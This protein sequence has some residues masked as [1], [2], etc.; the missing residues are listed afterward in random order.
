MLWLI[1]KTLFAVAL[2]IL[3]AIGVGAFVYRLLPDN[4]RP[5]ERATFILLGGI[6]LLSTALFLVGQIWFT[7][8]SITLVLAVAAAHMIPKRLS[9]PHFIVSWLHRIASSL[10][11]A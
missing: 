11:L 1:L 7:P 9:A 5:S 4:L 3:G 10:G 2:L 6:G 8:M